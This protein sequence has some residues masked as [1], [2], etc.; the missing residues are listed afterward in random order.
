M[1]S[2]PK[3]LILQHQID[4]ALASAKHAEL[5]RDARIADMYEAVNRAER[6]ESTIAALKEKLARLSDAIERM[7]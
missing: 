3:C 1:T 6:A 7:P 5:V 2:C 4:A